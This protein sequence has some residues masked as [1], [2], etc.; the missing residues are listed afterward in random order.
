MH[1]AQLGRYTHMKKSSKNIVMLIL[2]LSQFTQAKEL[3]TTLDIDCDGK[4]EEVYVAYKDD[5]FTISMLISSTNEKQ[6]LTF[7]LAQPTMQAATCGKELT[8]T[9]FESD[10][11]SMKEFS[12]HGYKHAP[13]CYDLNIS[14]GMC[15]AIN[16]FYNHKSKKIIWWRH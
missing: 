9:K 16:I 1:A 12:E 8:Y 7:G 15:D 2:F 14:D 3:V 10:A 11:D 4:N 6:D 5:Q 13:G